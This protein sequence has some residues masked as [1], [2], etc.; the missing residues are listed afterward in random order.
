MPRRTT[1]SARCSRGKD[2]L[3]EAIEHFRAALASTPEYPDALNNLGYSLLLAGRDAEARALYEKALALQ[4][5][6]PEAL[7]N[8]GLLLGRMGE[9]EQ[10][11]AL[12]P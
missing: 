7:N 11:R 1:T 12:L 10:A 8:L 4:P 3:D 5:D 6:F 2:E 9:L